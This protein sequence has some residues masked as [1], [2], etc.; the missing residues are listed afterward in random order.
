MK[1][2][3]I[4]TLGLLF[5]LV[6]GFSVRAAD[7]EEAIVQFGGT[8]ESLEVGIGTEMGIISLAF[9][10]TEDYSEDDIYD[11]EIPHDNYNNLGEQ[12]IG[13]EIGVDL[14]RTF[15]VENN[16]FVYGGG[17]IY[18]QQIRELVESNA[19]GDIYTQSEGSDYSFAATAGATY[20]FH[21]NF[22]ASLGYHTRRGINFKINLRDNLWN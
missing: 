22:G 21:D 20:L 10:A 5:L 6:L 19:T 9:R 3:A 16:I 1:K 18:Y 4:F 17:G 13:N 11:Y 15:E 2:I 7:Y 14:V 12:N 8:P